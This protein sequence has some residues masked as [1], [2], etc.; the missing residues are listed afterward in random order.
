MAAYDSWVQ[1]GRHNAANG[2]LMRTHPL[3][4]ICLPIPRAKKLETARQYSLI[5]HADPR[6]VV[7]CCICTLLISDIFRG[8]VQT[9]GH[10][11]D[12]LE[13]AFTWV[14]QGYGPETDAQEFTLDR[15][16]FCRHVYSTSLASLELDDS[17]KMGYVY[18]ALGAAILCLH[19]AIRRPRGD[20][21]IFEDLI[22]ELVMQGG[23]ADT[24]ACCAAALLGA[25]L[26]YSSLPPHWRDG[27]K[28]RA[29]LFAKTEALCQVVG[30]SEGGYKGS[31]DPDTL[32]DLERG[33]LPREELEV[34][35]NRLLESLLLK[36]NERRQQFGAAVPEKQCGIKM[37]MRRLFSRKS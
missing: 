13:E 6:C 26:G 3:G 29:W 35:G 31:E 27:L 14:T 28:H 12:I 23:D 10:V 11:N 22:T 25:W 37:D 32:T 33:L 18:K 16:E 4:I 36:E 20:M 1:S 17:M 19:L 24:N 8:K 2:S 7:A 15:A 34:R 21:N 30:I 5:I 9:E